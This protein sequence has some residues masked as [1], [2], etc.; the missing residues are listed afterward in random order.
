M[1]FSEIQQLTGQTVPVPAPNY[2]FEVQYSAAM[3]EKFES[4]KQDRDLM[5]A[6]H[7][8]R[9]ENFHSIL[10]YG[11]QGHLSKVNLERFI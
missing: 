9:L 7:G 11:L 3:S 10:H 4:L 8:S 6:F 1:Q 2:T 5:Y